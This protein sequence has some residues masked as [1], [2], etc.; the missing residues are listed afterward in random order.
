M[1]LKSLRLPACLV[2]LTPT[3]GWAESTNALTLQTN[4]PDVGL[5]AIRALG[6]FVLVL[7]IFLAGVWFF[8]KGQRMAWR[9]SGAPKLAIL[10][11]R[12][13][14]NRLALHVVSYE[15]H[16]LLLGASPAGLVMLTRLPVATVAVTDN[17]NSTPAERSAF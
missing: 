6:A 5:S 16:R 12:S 15:Q 13:L 8:R 2:W 10:E 11:T 4:L 7:A 1:K 14:G 9:K 17:E 3:S